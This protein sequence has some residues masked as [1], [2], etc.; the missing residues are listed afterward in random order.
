MLVLD[1]NSP[2]P[3]H[4]PSSPSTGF[5][6]PRRM[7][8]E[9]PP[10]GPI[11]LIAEAARRTTRSISHYVPIELKEQVIRELPKSSIYVQNFS[12]ICHLLNDRYF[13]KLPQTSIDNHGM[14][15]KRI[16]RGRRGSEGGGKEVGNAKEKWEER[17]RG[18]E[19]EGEGGGMCATNSSCETGE[20]VICPECCSIF[21]SNYLE[22]LYL[23]YNEC[24]ICGS[25]DI[26]V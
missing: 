18:K 26:C 7:P 12:K 4:L 17:Q 19:S 2:I 9:V 8:G 22:Y 24:P 11:A 21:S 20:L 16:G 14:E 23:L 15:P 5:S 25:R 10:H 13:V 6:N 1:K 3:S